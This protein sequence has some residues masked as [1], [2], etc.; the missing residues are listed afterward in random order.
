MQYA[1][2]ILAITMLF[3]CVFTLGIYLMRGRILLANRLLLIFA[4][5]V[6]AVK[7]A[8]F[9]YYA[10]EG[11]AVRFPAE[12]STL[13][14]IVFALVIFFDKKKVAYPFAAYAAFISG[15]AFNLLVFIGQDTFVT[16]RESNVWLLL[17]IFVHDVLLL[18][19][20]LMMGNFKFTHKTAWQIP[21][22]SAV[23]VGWAF[24]AKYLLGYD[25]NLYTVRIFEASVF[26]NVWN[27]E[28]PGIFETAGYL[29]V[30]YVVL[31][32]CLIA[33]VVLFYFLNVYIY[34]HDRLDSYYL[35]EE[36]Y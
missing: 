16:M 20:L 15:V 7:L 21:L 17:N 34:K 13:S 19:S 10:V 2:L 9:I 5:F 4:A 8:Q 6:L 35:D 12:Y 18:G 31:A 24:I 30:Y 36:E 25:G 22:G 1:M 27:T 11:G 3:L 29:P 14:C 23:M 32:L 28:H 33:S 26:D